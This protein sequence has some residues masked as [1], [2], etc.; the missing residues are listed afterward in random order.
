MLTQ[1][2]T[3]LKYESARIG[4]LADENTSLQA[5]IDRLVRELEN[6]KALLKN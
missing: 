6:G 5:E 1:E 2:V 4:Q 3:R